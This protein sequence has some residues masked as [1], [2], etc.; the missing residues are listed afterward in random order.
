M[1]GH[2]SQVHGRCLQLLHKDQVLKITY[3]TTCEI[4]VDAMFRVGHV[5]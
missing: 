5:Y 2:V 3:V 1:R 4:N